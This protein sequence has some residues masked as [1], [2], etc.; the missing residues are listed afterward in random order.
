M[1]NFEDNKLNK[2][3]IVNTPSGG[4]Q[5][6]NFNLNAARSALYDLDY[7]T[8]DA[9]MAIARRLAKETGFNIDKAF[10]AGFNTEEVISKLTGI[11]S[12]GFVP[13]AIESFSE[14]I[15]PG[16]AAGFGFKKGFDV[17]KPLGKL[18]RGKSLPF[19]AGIFGTR[20]I[21]GLVGAA[22]FGGTTKAGQD[23]VG[24]KLGLDMD[25]QRLASDRPAEVF[26][27]TA[28]YF[29]GGIIPTNRLLATIGDDFSI[30]P[31]IKLAENVSAGA[32]TYSVPPSSFG[33]KYGEG[34]SAAL[35]DLG[36]L[37]REK[38]SKLVIPELGAS[39][40]A[41]AAGAG[42][43]FVFPEDNVSRF[44]AETSAAIISPFRIVT[45][46]AANA[47]GGF[48]K[49]LGK[50]SKEK[51]AES[52]A[53]Y[54]DEQ[55]SKLADPESKVF[56][57]YQRGTAAESLSQI[58]E[59]ARTNTGLMGL[60]LVDEF[61]NPLPF[62]PGQ[63]SGSVLLQILENLISQRSG[64]EALRQNIKSSAQEGLNSINRL[65]VGLNRE[66]SDEALITAADLEVRGIESILQ[67]EANNVAANYLNF[68]EKLSN[69]DE[70]TITPDNVL[71]IKERSSRVA[72]ERLDNALNNSKKVENSLYADIKMTETIKPVELMKAIQDD[73]AQYSVDAVLDGVKIPKANLP[74][75]ESL[76]SS[77]KQKQAKEIDQK[78]TP[79]TNRLENL[80]LRSQN[81]FERGERK[82]TKETVDKRFEIGVRK[83]VVP[84]NIYQQTLN[85]LYDLIAPNKSF[86]ELN[87]EDFQKALQQLEKTDKRKTSGF[88]FDPSVTGVKGTKEDVLQMSEIISTKLNKQQRNDVIGI[89]KNNIK[90]NNLI[91]EIDGLLDQ[92][93]IILDRPDELEPI[94]LNKLTKT[95]TQIRK[96][97]EDAL[98]KNEKNLARRYGNIEKAITRDLL[99]SVGYRTSPDGEVVPSDTK[100]ISEVM[101]SEQ[102]KKQLRAY[103]FTFLRNEAFERSFAGKL[104]KKQRDKVNIVDA[105]TA[106]HYLFRNDDDSSAVYYEQLDNAINFL[107]RMTKQELKGVQ[108]ETVLDP[109]NPLLK[110]LSTDI[111][112]DT[113]TFNKSVTD[114][115]R[116]SL[117]TK[118][119]P[120]EALLGKIQKGVRSR[121]DDTS[122]FPKSLTEEAI[123]TITRKNLDNFFNRYNRVFELNPEMVGLKADLENPITR[124][125]LQRMFN[126]DVPS[127]R[128]VNMFESPNTYIS[129]LQNN[130][131]FGQLIKNSPTTV[132]HNILTTKSVKTPE[133]QLKNLIDFAK[134]P[135]KTE[136]TVPVK[137]N[138][139]AIKYAVVDFA[140]KRTAFNASKN[141]DSDN[142]D[143]APFFNTFFKEGILKNK[144]KPKQNLI[145]FLVQEN[146]VEKGF[147]NR[148]IQ[149]QKASK[150]LNFSRDIQLT[151]KDLTDFL[152]GNGLLMQYLVKVFGALGG[153]SLN[154][155]TLQAPQ[156]GASIAD[157][158][159]NNMPNLLINDLIVSALSPSITND[160][161]FSSIVNKSKKTQ[162]KVDAVENLGFMVGKLLSFPFNLSSI[163]SRTSVDAVSNEDADELNTE[164]DNQTSIKPF[165]S[166]ETNLQPVTQS[167]SPPSASSEPTNIVQAPSQPINRE[168]Y[169]AMFPDDIT[170][171]LIEQQNIGKGI[172]SLIG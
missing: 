34:I 91:S 18:A 33:A 142:V 11:K 67:L 102:G 66:G 75:A 3:S 57:Q 160:S 137:D 8:E 20:L 100:I 125:I 161:V 138:L 166:N 7:S 12:E 53:N 165:I 69:I 140:L 164:P 70:T 109:K 103:V 162:Q 148:L 122:L 156:F 23:I 134:N 86:N 60:E 149:F 40:A 26:G 72:K 95:R 25:P 48:Q 97:K 35:R 147:K 85:Q 150:N 51:R 131:R 172:G 37:A 159:I 47:S 81:I 157:N 153:R 169:A 99:A 128:K 9:Q 71:R 133:A 76:I 54:L 167:A 143:M 110:E 17:T 52:V 151:D 5:V 38:P 114:F 74:L 30:L 117:F 65:I 89:L 132:I 163:L 19:Q 46:V 98:A 154:T 158:F 27:E 43:E 64:N 62:T 78:I 119:Q 116:A 28:A 44:L 4:K 31:A 155:G 14:N 29:T 77:N 152:E 104:N 146:V 111:L 92:R 113:V 13:T 63:R 108:G 121:E 50:F 68:I 55:L 73:M 83:D 129:S 58:D 41:S 141:L 80:N 135:T 6:Q 168:A 145:D 1:D 115:I 24:E 105:D 139:E 118:L 39:A 15:L 61:G 170:S 127:F 88:T 22:L 124:E 106:L 49:I 144:N 79:K 126:V 36:K 94:T 130:E 123:P 93:K 82:I 2:V 56:T 32:K 101:K 45:S 59:A 42:S 87:S 107:N 171:P 16:T 21:S 90:I 136:N 96:D 120:D 10:N 84:T 112:D